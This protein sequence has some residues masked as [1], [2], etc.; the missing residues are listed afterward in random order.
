MA[1]GRRDLK[2]LMSELGF[3]L[4]RRTGAGHFC[5][6]H[7]SGVRYITPSSPSDYRG[8]RN[9]R[10]DVRRILNNTAS[11]DGGGKQ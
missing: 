1:S 6:Q 3:T 9:M 5:W 10:A 2:R 8:L 4:L 11:A 7:S